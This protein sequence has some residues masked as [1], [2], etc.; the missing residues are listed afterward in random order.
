M[1]VPY[2]EQ[3]P[4][5]ALGNL[6]ISMFVILSNFCMYLHIH[7]GGQKEKRTIV[8]LYKI[9]F[10]MNRNEKFHAT[11]RRDV[12]SPKF[13]WFFL[14]VLSFQTIGRKWHTLFPTVFWT[15][16]SQRRPLCC[17]PLSGDQHSRHHT[18]PG[19]ECTCR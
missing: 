14:L 17:V 18:E 13:I 12:F 11:L 8:L 5:L 1:V 16:L 10:L 15:I 3:S 4:A 7:N 19:S 6:S 2:I 9:I